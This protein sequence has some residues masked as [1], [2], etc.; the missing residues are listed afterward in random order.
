MP[1][2]M[3]PWIVFEGSPDGFLANHRANMAAHISHARFYLGVLNGAL[4]GKYIAALPEAP[5]VQAGGASGKSRE[6]NIDVM[7]SKNSMPSGVSAHRAASSFIHPL[8]P[9]S[10]RT[11]PNA[12]SNRNPNLASKSAIRIPSFC[13]NP[14]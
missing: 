6:T 5:T 2:N 1:P 14:R 7:P 12:V 4:T 13:L 10:A 8:F 9:I 11:S 3:E